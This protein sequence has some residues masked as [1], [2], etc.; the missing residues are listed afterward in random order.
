[1][2]GP[3]IW[4]SPNGVGW[5]RESVLFP[6]QTAFTDRVNSLRG[7]TSLPLRLEGHLP[8]TWVWDRRLRE[9]ALV[10]D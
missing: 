1:M 7:A 2:I 9:H 6:I 3:T 4:I 10:S 5:H 8:T